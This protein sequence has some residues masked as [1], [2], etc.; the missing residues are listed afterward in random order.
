MQYN[1]DDW[2]NFSKS[3]LICSHSSEE[4]PNTEKFK[5]LMDSVQELRT[6]AGVPF[7]VT[8]CYRS[9]EHPIEARKDK[10]GMH[11]IAA[12]DIQ[13]GVEDCHRIVKKAFELGFTGIGINLSGDYSKRFIHLDKRLIPK[14]WSY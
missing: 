10:P 7:K 5:E 6:W 14:I 3:E 9:P 11:S 2:P 8:S 13:V 4:N 1:Y 12:I